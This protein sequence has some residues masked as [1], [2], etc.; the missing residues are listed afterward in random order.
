[1]KK[2]DITVA[3]FAKVA[4]LSLPYYCLRNNG[5]LSLD[6]SYL[7]HKNV[8]GFGSGLRGNYWNIS[9]IGLENFKGCIERKKDS[10]NR[11]LFKLGDE[12]IDYSREGLIDILKELD[13]KGVRDYGERYYIV[14]L[15]RRA[16][17]GYCSDDP[18][19]ERKA[20]VYVELDDLQQYLFEPSNL[21]YFRLQHFLQ[22]PYKEVQ[23]LGTTG[24]HDFENIIKV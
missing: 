13:P 21:V 4:D 2:N 19:G 5:Y 23:K 18:D 14:E 6:I 7:T 20:N 3:D 1:M 9:E 17:K 15:I 22:K 11:I 10:L 16:R 12:S 24:L 8:G